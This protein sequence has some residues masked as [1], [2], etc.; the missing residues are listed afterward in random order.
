MGTRTKC[1]NK[2]RNRLEQ[3]CHSD[4]PFGLRDRI[5]CCRKAWTEWRL[6][7]NPVYEAGFFLCCD[8]AFHLLRWLRRFLSYQA[9]TFLSAEM[10]PGRI[11]ANQY[12]PFRSG[13]TP[14][15]STIQSWLENMERSLSLCQSMITSW[16]KSF[17]NA[18]CMSRSQFEPGKTTIPE[19]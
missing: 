7:K 5:A 13:Y 19:Y 4:H 8:W 11:A 18:S 3:Y 17:S 14:P 16:F 15:G 10:L 1:L 12:I 9:L 6:I 2:K